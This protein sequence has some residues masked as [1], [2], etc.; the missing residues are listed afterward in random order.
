MSKNFRKLWA[1]VSILLFISGFFYLFNLTTNLGLNF[2][3]RSDLTQ[4]REPTNDFELELS[5]LP[6]LSTY[7]G[8]GQ[9]Q[10][11]TEY[12]FAHFGNNGL[13][14]DNDDNATIIVPEN[15]N[16]NEVICNISN[17]YDFNNIYVNETFNSG[18]DTNFWSNYSDRPQNVTA[19]WYNN[20]AGENDSIYLRFDEAN[21]AGS[22]WQYVDSWVNY[23]FYVPKINIPTENWNLNFNY[24]A[25]FSDTEWLSGLGGTK[26]YARVD[27]DGYTQEFSKRLV[28]LNNK[29]IYQASEIINPDLSGITLPGTISL[30]FGVEYGNIGNNPTGYFQ[31]FF[32]NI[33]LSIST[34]PKPS[35]INLTLIDYTNSSW[36]TPISDIGDGEGTNN[37]QGI[38]N[39]GIGGKYHFF[40]F[41][42]NSSGRVILN[43]DFYAKATSSRKTKTFLGL[44][45]SEFVVE[46]N[47]ATTWTMYFPMKVSGTYGT[48]YYVNVSK[49]LNWNVTQVIDPYF[50][51]RINEVIG[52]GFGNS[53]LIIPNNIYIEGVWKIVVKAPNYV[54][55][56]NL[57]RKDAS[58]WSE[59]KTFHVDDI[60]KINASIDNSLIPSIDNTNATLKIF[61][62]NGSL[63]YQEGNI[64]VDSNGNVEFSD[65]TLG[66]SN[67][68][69][70]KYSAQI[71]WNDH[72]LNMS[73]VG[74]SLLQFNVIHE[75][76]LTAIDSNFNLFS[77][78]PL[79]IR[80]KFMDYDFNQSIP[81][82]T[83]TYSSTF[84]MFGTMIY[85]GFGIYFIDVD[86]S[87]LSYGDYY[88]SINASKSFY[89]NQTME[90]LIHLKILAQ[91]LDLEVPHYAL[92][93]NANSII[94]CNINITGAISG[95]LIYPVNISTDWFNPYNITDHN[96]GT[97]TLDFSTNNIP[98]SGY[99]ESYNIE[100]FVN[101]T[102]YENTNDFIT[103][104]VHPI[105]TQA[106]ANISLTSINSNEVVNLKVNYTLEGSNELITD[107]NC[108]VTWQG[109]SL[110]NP[111]SD[112]FN[113]MLFTNGLQVDYYTA[114][115]KLE[116][117]GFED[118]FESI[119]IIINEQDVNLTISINA[120]EIAAN[121]LIES[122]FKQT[123]NISARAYAVID[124][125]F[126]SGGM[127]TL[128]SNNFEKNF[129]ETPFT[130][131]S[132]S[133]ILN[134]VNFISGINNIFLR[135]EQ[136]NYTTKIFLFQ[137]FIKA[138]NV[139]LTTHI[140]YQEI[141]E[142]FLIERSFNQELQISCRAFA[143][144]EGV[145][146]S[147]GTITF[148]NGEY[149]F[150]LYENTG[151][152]F[153]RTILISTSTF[154]I[155]PNYAYL[156]F[157]QNNYTTTIF[158]FQ[159]F[160]NQIEIEIDTPG[161]E[162]I[163]SG[164]PG[165]TVLIKLNLTENGTTNDIENAT[166]FYSWNFG[167]GYFNDIG[168]GIYELELH[169]PTGFGGNYDLK[170]IISKE[171]ILY[172]TKEF[173]LFIDINQVEG[174]NIF[175]WIIIFALVAISG[176][177]GA[178]SFRSYVILPKKRKREAELI[179]KIQVF[180]D[181][182]NIRAVIL[183]HRESGLP[184]Y[185]EE[186]SFAEKD[187]DSTLISGFVQAITAFS[188]SFV[189]KG[190]QTTKKLTT[191]Y[192]YLKTIIDL[193]F[194]FFQLLVCDFETVRI[195]LVLRDAPSERLK[196]QI[197]LLATVLHS[198][199]GEEF[200]SFSGSLN[201]LSIK[202]Q[203][204]LNQ[205]IFLHYNKEFEITPN[206]NYYESILE[207]DEL[208]NL[209]KRLI[210]VILSM[211][212]INKTFTIKDTIDLIEE[213]NEDL[214]LEAINTLIQRKIIISPY[215]PKL[216]QKK[217]QT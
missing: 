107:S 201:H 141:H 178:L 193:D 144:I 33:T 112:G 81:F 117:A 180:K 91:P 35:Q 102:H 7:S 88:F 66:S 157:Q 176:I 36:K 171:G 64:S 203:D 123:I 29:T 151:Y 169:L 167:T 124:E 145:F 6:S 217:K 189:E 174:P 9:A 5:D 192:E 200:I 197:Y 209:E 31:M 28:D 103:L 179:S 158:T 160:V 59:N 2:I 183:I 109:S 30:L 182:W 8:V 186:I 194:R 204:F 56:S 195:L 86:T 40:G 159:V 93:G 87:S 154:S 23:T 116:K 50:N 51:N 188:E 131:F 77:G 215:F 90:N 48:D 65:I 82:A 1:I 138:Q 211:T 45:G 125:H 13:D 62:S 165:E 196:K 17:I 15:W 155:G 130:Y 49:P 172:K 134:G 12:G 44:E 37:L 198:Q 89:E 60:L 34:I 16:A 11:V 71:I 46:N 181:V 148:I 73:Q 191:D 111:V 97:Y 216:N 47:T 161:F 68:S 67:A 119:T 140:N 104:L 80:V 85:I 94:S 92:E 150:E 39:G 110:I 147:G 69:T 121:D 128:I 42:T 24:G 22:P 120:E 142:D 177:L 207:T 95:S 114:L 137:L 26:H 74:F 96:N 105:S 113:I 4:D 146:L 166:V 99:L 19:G 118:A 58:I 199:F 20:P 187:Q 129:T 152:W 184:I 168:G 136:A 98:T 127:V 54:E 108:T 132:A 214:V 3:E 21:E 53:T 170:L 55:F 10:N 213:K 43:S 70:G 202:F 139:N 25:F 208:T 27:V 61:S 76:N 185:S 32:D 210:N 72:N 205:F 52:A 75:T 78:D 115:F 206:K 79:L 41:E 83:V 57:F 101:K 126:L 133:L 149:E 175:I 164:A 14:L 153:N 212:K 106:T 190:F 18:I 100:I 38:W 122:Y 156:R 143:E 163:I 162:G 84:G 135:F 173:T 63:W